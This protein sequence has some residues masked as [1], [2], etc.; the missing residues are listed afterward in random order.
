LQGLDI[1]LEIG[2]PLSPDLV[3]SVVERIECMGA[4]HCFVLFGANVAEVHFRDIHVNEFFGSGW[5]L[6]G[7][8][9]HRVRTRAQATATPT[10]PRDAGGEATVLTNQDDASEIVW[11]ELPDYAQKACPAMLNRPDGPTGGAW[12]GGGGP[13]ANIQNVVTSS[14]FCTAWLVDSNGAPLRL[15]GVRNEGCNGL[16]E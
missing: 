8:S 2:D 7:S 13:T 3:G 11:E 16:C 10:V 12:I 4:R 6:T 15:Q 5:L 9:G 14:D 1:G